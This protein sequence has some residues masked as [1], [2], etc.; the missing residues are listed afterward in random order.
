MKEGKNASTITVQNSRLFFFCISYNRIYINAR[1][2][3]GVIPFTPRAHLHLDA[4]VSRRK[5]AEGNI[6]NFYLPLACARCL[7]D[8]RRARQNRPRPL[9]ERR[10]FFYTRGDFNF[11]FASRKVFII[12]YNYTS[13]FVYN[14]RF[15]GAFFTRRDQILCSS[16]SNLKIFFIYTNRLEQTF[17]VAR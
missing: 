15:F 9:P 13:H 1:A 6:I 5:N 10:Y 7:L 12:H 4:Y 2:P 16:A 17:S 3:R 8:E 11:F 14:S